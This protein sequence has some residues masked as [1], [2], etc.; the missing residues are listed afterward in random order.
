MRETCSAS[1]CEV[2]Q[3]RSAQANFPGHLRPSHAS[4]NALR[5]ERC[6][7]LPRVESQNLVL[8]NLRQRRASIFVVR[9]FWHEALRRAMEPE[10]H[11]QNTISLGRSEEHTSE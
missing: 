11:L 5:I 10:E 6:V 8:G 4:R 2:S 9:T 7:E 1:A 3:T